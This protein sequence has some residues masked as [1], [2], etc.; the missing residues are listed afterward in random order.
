MLRTFQFRLQPNAGQRAMLER[1]LAD[2]CETYNACLEERIGAWK[3]Q[4]K[5]ITY[6]NQQDELT[7]LRQDPAFQWIALMPSTDKAKVA[8]ANR[9]YYLANRERLAEYRRQYRQRP[10]AIERARETEQKP[11]R[12]AMQSLAN[13]QRYIRKRDALRASHAKW[14]AE[15]RGKIN[16][17]N[18]ARY[19]NDPQYKLGLLLRNRLNLAIK[20]RAKTGSAIRLLGCSIPELMRHIEGLFLDGMNWGNWGSWHIDHA[21]PL[22]LFDL[23]DPGQLAKA[24]HYTNLQPLSKEANLKKGAQAESAGR[25]AVPVNPRGTSIRCSQ[26]GADVRKT[27]ADRQ[28]LCACGASLDRDHNA[29]INVLALG[30][31]VAGLAPSESIPALA[32]ESMYIIPTR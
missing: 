18:T 17:R 14:V 23:E 9:K 28:H 15:N 5:S 27:L 6:R 19:Q 31:S 10:D 24:C 21:R 3:L 29:A 7:E 13:A 8:A 11:E 26:C 16:N 4:R 1:I 12:K 32:G 30:K 20:N 22:A 2:N 25:W